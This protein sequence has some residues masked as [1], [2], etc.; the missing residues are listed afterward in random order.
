MGC[1]INRQRNGN[2]ILENHNRQ[3]QTDGKR[4]FFRNNRPDGGRVS[5]GILPIVVAAVKAVSLG[6]GLCIDDILDPVYILH[7]ERLIKAIVRAQLGKGFG[8]HVFA[9]GDHLG[10]VG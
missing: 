6:I 10:S 9:A 2:Q 1:G 5:K 7:Q 4:K 3:C 8:V